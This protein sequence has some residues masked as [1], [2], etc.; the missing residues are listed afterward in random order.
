M[1]QTE[2]LAPA[3]A[4]LAACTSSP[5]SIR[6]I[7]HL[8][9]YGTDRLAVLAHGLRGTDYGAEELTDGLK[10]TPAPLIPGLRRAYGDRRVAAFAAIIGLKAPGASL[11]DI[12]STLK[13]IPGFARMQEEL[14]GTSGEC[15]RDTM[16]VPMIPASACVPANPRV[17]GRK[18]TPIIR[19][20]RSGR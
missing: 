2:E 16:L 18:C 13:T 14:L 20:H 1:S 11:D 15:S 6:G 19:K 8:R 12:A 5:S 10:V 9:D 7:V 4:A 17:R 3:L